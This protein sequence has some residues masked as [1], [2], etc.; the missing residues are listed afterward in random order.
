MLNNLTKEDVQKYGLGGDPGFS[1]ARNEAVIKHT[2][3][4]TEDIYKKRRKEADEGIAERSE[5]VYSY[6]R[7]MDDNNKDL[8][9]EDYA[10]W[11]NLKALWGENRLRELQDRALRLGYNI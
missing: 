6:I 8:K 11:H 7:H 2:I 9:I 3:K 4:R 1:A 5:L 10:G